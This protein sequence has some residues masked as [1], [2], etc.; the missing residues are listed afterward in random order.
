MSN[1][2]LWVLLVASIGLISL[3]RLNLVCWMFVSF[4]RRVKDLKKQYGSWAL[5]TG[6]TDGIG[7]AMAMELACQGLNLVLVCRN[8]EKLEQVSRLIMKKTSNGSTTK[9]R[10]VVFD[11]S[12]DLDNGIDRIRGHGRVRGWGISEKCRCE[13]CCQVLPCG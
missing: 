7:K 1:Q 12:A 6:P 5:V 2:P 3:V 11:F 4:F 9:I 13:P 8:P 10:T